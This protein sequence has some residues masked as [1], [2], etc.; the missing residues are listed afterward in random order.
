[1]NFEEANFIDRQAPCRL[2]CPVHVLGPPREARLAVH[3]FAELLLRSAARAHSA[4]PA[5]AVPLAL[6]ALFEATLVL[7]ELMASDAQ[8]ELALVFEEPAV[9]PAAEG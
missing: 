4:V 1:M 8:A 2:S 5:A 3:E 7:V 6:L 9:A